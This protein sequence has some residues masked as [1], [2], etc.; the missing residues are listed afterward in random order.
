MHTFTFSLFAIF[1]GAAVLSTVAL[2]T[3]QSLLVAYMLLGLLL[4]PFGLHW[5]E[6][7][8][9]VR[10]TGEIGIIFLLFLLGLDLQPQKL[11]HTFKKI[12]LIGV[13]SSAIFFC[14]GFIFGKLIGYAP[15]ACFVTGIA[16]MF[17]S[18]IVGIKLLPTTVLHH[19]HTGELMISVLLLQ[20]I[21]AILLLTVL[22][23]LQLNA[24]MGH[25]FIFVTLAFPGLIA[26][27]F[28][29][30]RYV[31]IRL[32]SRFNRIKEYLFLVAIAW[33][34]SM[35]ELARVLHLSVEMGAF[36]AG[37]SVA[38]SPIAIYIAESLK[39][40]RDFFLVLFFFSVGASFDLAEI[41]T[42]LIPAFILAFVVV[43]VKPLVYRY[44]FTW[45]GETKQVAWEVGA[46]LGQN[47]EFSLVIAY[48]ALQE[49]L[50]HSGVNTMIQA[51]TMLTFIVSSYYVVLRYPT[52]VALN[53][54]LRRD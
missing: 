33:C 44:L 6:S 5:V 16:V 39:P 25:E 41:K 1:T 3:R 43:L 15:M 20:D 31:L 27:A 14:I 49:Q 9:L 23:S 26:F 19:Q 47:S 2:V 8:P 42:L 29:F 50:V 18:T 24:S 7:G 38:T 40:I 37:V 17:S 54:R 45:L 11:L 48:T 32:I 12:S 36:I 46:R 51:V 28:L 4:G 13:V 21:I 53:D 30:E 22:R 10:R 35:A 52:P 34:L